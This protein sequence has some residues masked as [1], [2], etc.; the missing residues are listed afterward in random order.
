MNPGASG[1]QE[2]S[3]PV[4]SATISRSPGL[5]IIP[6]TSV[7]EKSKLASNP[8]L[9]V[10]PSVLPPVVKGDNEIQPVKKDESKS[11]GF[12][13]WLLT[14]P[15][16]EAAKKKE[17]DVVKAETQSAPMPAPAPARQDY[18]PIDHIPDQGT[19]SNI[20]SVVPDGSDAKAAGDVAIYP[21]QSPPSVEE[22]SETLKLEGKKGKKT[23]R[24]C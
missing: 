1:S 17:A 7:R 19:G 14:D 15:K 6:P 13:K 5:E 24:F 9:V 10:Y 3:L 8:D 22:V 12:V 16:K 21:P 20:Q 2:S 18:V 11:G 23:R 4:R